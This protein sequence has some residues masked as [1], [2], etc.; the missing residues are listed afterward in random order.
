M[1]GGGGGFGTG[2]SFR[3]VSYGSLSLFVAEH[4]VGNPADANGEEGYR[5]PEFKAPGAMQP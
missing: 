4:F 1:V 2:E 3:S 5:E